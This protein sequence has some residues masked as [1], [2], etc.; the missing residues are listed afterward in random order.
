[1]R[2]WRAE[3]EEEEE[4]EGEGEGEGEAAGALEPRQTLRR[5]VAPRVQP[6]QVQQVQQVRLEP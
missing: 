2:R 5:Q 1:L 6:E 4:G 3:V